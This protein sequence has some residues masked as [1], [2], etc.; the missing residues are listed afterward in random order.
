MA[1]RTSYFYQS[2][3]GSGTVYTPIA[4]KVTFNT[5]HITVPKKQFLAAQQP[6]AEM[7]KAVSKPVPR[8]RKEEVLH[9]ARERWIRSM[10]E[11]EQR[12]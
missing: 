12:N 2:L 4:S 11:K 7:K 6:K 9:D 3:N 1:K 10:V 8:E 5:L